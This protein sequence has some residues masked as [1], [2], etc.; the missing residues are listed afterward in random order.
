MDY[1]EDYERAILGIM[2]TDNSLIDIIRGRIGQDSF[3]SPKCRFLFDR[4]VGQWI[5]NHCATILSLTTECQKMNPAEIASLTDTVSTTSNWEFYVT[6]VRDYH[7]M[8]TIRRD[9]AVVAE[10]VDVDNVAN[11][12]AGLSSRISSY[13]QYEG[14]KGT[15]MQNLCMAV[16]EQ[17]QKAH[18]E[19]RRYKGYD[20]GWAQISDILNGFQ[21]KKL[22]VIGARPSIGKTAFAMGLLSNF[23]R[24]GITCCAISL[25]MSCESLFY[26]ML[27]VES[28]VPMWQLESGTVMEYR[29]GLQ[30]LERGLNTLYQFPMNIVDT[31]IDDE[32]MVYS[33]IRY[34]ARIKGTKVFLID[35]LGLVE[36]TDRQRQKYEQ[37][38]H[39]TK[40]LHKMAK[41]LDV[42]IILLCQ[43]SRGAEGK[44]PNMSLLRESGNIEQDADVVMFLHRERDA[45]EKQIPTD[46]IVEKN[47][48]GKIG[49][50]KML[51]LP[52]YTKFVE[53]S[54]TGNSE[55]V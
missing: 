51:F 19:K 44:K 40:T 31:D 37:V 48:D 39:I 20:S 35:H 30:K 15:S 42:V 21:E 45:N 52:S 1:N 23:C 5:K 10:K 11:T 2:L 54:S 28:K 34:E 47:R 16:P 14:D 17:I 33:K 49:T 41:E 22:Y 43:L 25:E 7:L 50:A 26:R 38:G 55:A 3:Y 12:V 32:D 18:S 9:M 46:V 6:K 4:I 13:M 29:D 8:R 24:Q 27:S 53:D 36:S